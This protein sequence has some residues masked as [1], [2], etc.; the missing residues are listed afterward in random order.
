MADV[1]D[2]GG[3]EDEPPGL[4]WTT[5]F[6]WITVYAACVLI[7]TYPLVLTFGSTLPGS[8]G[9]PLQHLWIM[10]WY[11]TCLL[12]G[13]SVV[14]C[15]D[16]Q[17]PVGAPLGNFSPLH[18]QSLI[19][20][21]LSLALGNDILA[22]NM[23]WL[24]GLVFTGV[25]TLVL[26]WHVLRDRPCA[27][28]AGLMAMLSGPMLLHARAHLEL[29]YVGSIPLFLVAW[30]RF[31]DRPGWARLAT[32]ALAYIVVAMSAAYYAVFAI[33]PA[34]LYAAWKGVGAGWRGV[35]P[36]AVARVG[37]FLGFGALTLPML[38]F[39][40]ASQLW[41]MSHGYA[42]PRTSHEFN[43]YGA[44]LWGYFIPTIFHPLGRLVMP[45][46]AYA[47]AGYGWGMGER[48]SYLGLVTL[49]LVHRA[50]ARRA[51]FRMAGFWWATF[52]LLLVLSFGASW[53]IGP[54][55]VWL[56]ASWLKR[57]FVGFQMIR[58]PA[59]FNLLV[60]VA[61]A[62][63]AGA[64]LRHLL[65]RLPNRP[66]RSL[67]FA[68]LAAIAVADLSMVPFAACPVP[69]M[70]SSYAWL[71]GRDPGATI[72]EV[73]QFGSGGTELS[74][75]CAYW[76]SIHRGKTTGGYSGSANV[77]FDYLM[78]GPA[79]F[80]ANRLTSPDFLADPGRETFGVTPEVDALGYTWL[81]M[82]V[83]D[84]RYIVLHKEAVPEAPSVRLDRVRELLGPALIYEDGATGVYDRARLRPPSRPVL[85]CTEGWRPAWG[86][87]VA[88]ILPK[89]ARVVIYNPD[90]DRELTL[91]FVG[92][93]FRRE[94]AVLVR[95]QGDVVARWSVRPDVSQVCT[96][97]PFHLPE[98]I[99]E[100]TIESDRES[101]PH[102]R[103]EE[104]IPGDRRPY[105]LKV[106]GLALQAVP[107]VA[108][109][110]R[111]RH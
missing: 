34:G 17:Y 67:A 107:Q 13:R 53:H 72:L 49:L 87:G 29:I 106:A 102:R 35:R 63:L 46:D 100:L 98:G 65:A 84:L 33:V 59:R 25:G 74:A 28:F 16:I 110:A 60:A 5:L 90:P 101:P 23:A 50:A 11:R 86:A 14:F 81:Y 83:H 31:V 111:D 27:G 103:S 21:P 54:H 42:L 4:G 73:P 19:F 80:E 41:S 57:W 89:L 69:P 52:A 94:R 38:F 91:T 12:E 1:E 75:K 45:V 88:R 82:T 36:W 6:G 108:S 9:D 66:A 8:L 55:K 96:S 105:S 15:P 79:P 70:P 92:S 64:G 95:R 37:W 26:T 78:I 18:L 68:A 30:L 58:V 2:R 62:V 109:Q 48:A 7:A 77:R 93:A 20:L 39:L 44:P 97:P 24:A 51:G 85:L 99:Q 3:V 104:A 32:A 56:P 43:A 71:L 61:A 22:F 76:Q 40:F 47:A 10:R